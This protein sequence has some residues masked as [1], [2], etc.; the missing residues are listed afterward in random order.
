MATINGGSSI[1]ERVWDMIV[2]VKR[3]LSA[4]ALDGSNQRKYVHKARI[5][6]C[7]VVSVKGLVCLHLPPAHV[8]KVEYQADGSI[9]T[10]I[11]LRSQLIEV[12][13][14]ALEV[15]LPC[16]LDSADHQG[17]IR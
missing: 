11:R 9:G 13:Q 8:E 12:C 6:G 4:F 17:P 15:P 16:A 5:R 7:D 1:I 10:F 2:H 14:C 3:R